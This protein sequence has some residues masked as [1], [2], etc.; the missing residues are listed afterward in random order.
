[1]NKILTCGTGKFVL[2]AWNQSPNF[3]PGL[4]DGK[5]KGGASLKLQFH[6]GSFKL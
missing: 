4:K 3:T 6:K 2:S 1:M 5:D